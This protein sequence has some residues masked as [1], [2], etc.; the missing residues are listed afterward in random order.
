MQEPLLIDV[1]A[2]SADDLIAVDG[3]GP[4]LAQRIVQHRQEHGPFGTLD[5]LTQIRGIGPSSLERIRSQLSPAPHSPEP[6]LARS[7]AP[8]ASGIK[9]EAG[10]LV[11]LSIPEG[12][13]AETMAEIPDIEEVAMAEDQIARE[14][15]QADEIPAQ[16]A[17]AADIPEQEPPV[18]ENEPAPEAEAEIRA[19]QPAAEPEL[20]NELPEPEIEMEEEAPELDIEME[21]EPPEIEI[22]LPEREPDVTPEVVLDE[23][24]TAADVTGEEEPEEEMPAATT[25]ADGGLGFW[26]GFLLVAAGALVGALVML[27]VLLAYSGTLSYASRNEVEALSRNMDTIYQNS[28]IAWARLDRLAAEN[29]DLVAKVD[30]LM[31]LS[32]RVSDLEQGVSDLRADMG[33]IEGTIANVEAD[34]ASLRETYDARLTEVDATLAAQGDLLDRMES[35]LG[36]V[37]ESIQGMEE[38]LGRY[39][40]F[41][42]ALRDLLI[43]LQG[44]PAAEAVEQSASE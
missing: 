36:A 8:H 5:E 15:M 32:G 11:S 43:D 24:E 42:G 34:L 26:R 14:S 18:E 2:A 6:S 28:E 39:D 4:A 3:I 44:P 33:S 29:A 37:R 41:F 19:E 25:D 16:E 30:R 27:L 13:Q 23:K 21:A 20:A 1:N 10:R 38:R 35:D 9:P 40:S 31:L 22:E 17:E 7:P 12:S